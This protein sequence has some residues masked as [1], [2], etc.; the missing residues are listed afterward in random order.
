MTE[1]ENKT[2]RRH[3]TTEQKFKIVKEQLTTKTSV[4]DICKKY[5]VLPNAFYRWLEDFFAGAKDGLERKKNGPTKAELRKIEEL[6]TKTRRQMEVIAEI[7]S[8][9]IDFKKKFGM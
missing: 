4:T 2:E 1:Q 6:E 3:F 9:N 7:T 8:E 5:D